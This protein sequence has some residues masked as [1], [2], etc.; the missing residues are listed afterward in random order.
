MADPPPC[1]P[2]NGRPGF[3][4]GFLGAGGRL[5]KARRGRFFNCLILLLLGPLLANGRT[6]EGALLHP[7]QGRNFCVFVSPAVRQGNG[8]FFARKRRKKKLC[9]FLARKR[10][11]CVCVCFLMFFWC[12]CAFWGVFLFFWG[13][14][15]AFRAL[16]RFFGGFIFRGEPSKAGNSCSDPRPLVALIHFVHSLRGPS[17]RCAMSTRGV[18]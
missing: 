18:R 7:R 1:A 16:A 15:F 3:P 5:P 4:F 8:H 17:A 11:L 14:F 2:T 9:F 10:D 12:F 6:V 13:V